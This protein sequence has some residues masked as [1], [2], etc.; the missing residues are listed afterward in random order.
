DEG[1]NVDYSKHYLRIGALLDNYFDTVTGYHT[2]LKDGVGTDHMFQD[3]LMASMA[4]HFAS[5]ANIETKGKSNV[6]DFS[7]EEIA[8]I[9]S[10]LRDNYG[11]ADLNALKQRLPQKAVDEKYDSDEVSRL[12]LDLANSRAGLEV[13]QAAAPLINDEG[14]EVGYAGKGTHK[15]THKRFFEMIE[16]HHR[17]YSKARPLTEFK[18]RE[19]AQQFLGDTATTAYRTKQETKNRI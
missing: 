6:D 17:P 10:H 11:V 3:S 15:G 12:L 16:E 19:Q 4:R 13:Q 5:G 2:N 7:A 8:K 9:N 18:S 1:R 14:F